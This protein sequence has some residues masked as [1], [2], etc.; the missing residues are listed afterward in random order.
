MKTAFSASW[1]S[2]KQPRK[3]R[4]YVYNAPLHIQRNFLSSHLSKELRQKHNIRAIT[5]RK[6]DKIKVMR[7]QHKNKVGKVERV[8]TKDCKVY[9]TGIDLAK[10]EGTKI[11]QP[12]HPSNL[13]ITELDLSDKKRLKN[14][15][16]TPETKIEK[17]IVSE[18]EKKEDISDL[19]DSEKEVKKVTKPKEEAKGDKK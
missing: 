5:I 4:K 9:V 14:G 1:K 7:G 8:K 2:S 11:L 18:I 16:K 12:L 15:S 3:Q 13:L 10:K 19:K 6:G 17:K